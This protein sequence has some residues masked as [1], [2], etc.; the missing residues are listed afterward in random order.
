MI[1][2]GIE[3]EEIEGMLTKSG[4]KKKTARSKIYMRYDS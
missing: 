2:L 4:M 1:Y 3:R